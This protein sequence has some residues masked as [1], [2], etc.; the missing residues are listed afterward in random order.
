MSTLRLVLPL[1]VSLGAP[2][3]QAA[4]LEEVLSTELDRAM[5]ALSTQPEKP[6]YIGLEVTES[7]TFGVSATDGTLSDSTRDVRRYLDVDL[8]VGTPELDSTHQLRGSGSYRMTGR[9][10]VFLPTVEEPDYA[11]R[12]I[13][14]RELNARYRAAAEAIVVVRSDQKVLVEEEDPAPDFEVRKP[15]V[16]HR[17]PLP[18]DLDQGEWERRLTEVAQRLEDAPAV[19]RSSVNINAATNTVTFVDTEGTRLVH[20]TNHIR[21]FLF[22]GA[23]AED[24]DEVTALRYL[25]VHDPHH[26]PDQKT[27][28]AWADDA[29]AEVERALAAPRGSPYSGPVML[30]GRAAG[31]FFHEVLGHRVEGHRQKRDDEGKTFATYVGKP[32]LPDF[33]DIYDDPTV[34]RLAE[35]DL[36]GYYHYDNEG[37][38]AQRAPIVEGGTFVGFLMGRS[39]IEGFTQSN[40]HGRRQVGRAPVTRMGNLIIDAE[41]ELD[42]AEMRRL[43]LVEIKKQGLEYG[44]IVDEIAGGFT[45]T[46]RMLP[47]AFN[48]R[49]QRAWKVYADGRPDELLRGIDLVGTPLVAFSNLLAAGGTVEVFN[50]YCGAESGMVPVSAVAP[51]VVFRRLEMQLKEKGSDRPPLLPKPTADQGGA[52]DASPTDQGGDHDVH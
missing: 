50:G 39:P 49:A 18:L 52:A 51:S 40:G 2:T 46:G 13:L 28:L 12:Q 3:A 26:L 14:W 34:E 43:L 36:N 10:A 23:I 31:V 17:P 33:I 24:G 15:V 35:T 29:I 7:R 25:D 11:L 45:L 5:L 8:R 19:Y 44:L 4:G 21:I 1:L 38:P 42:D 6:H 48:V 41:T 27:L 30:R 20:G 16:D 47:N 37:V 32:I 22:A 9:G